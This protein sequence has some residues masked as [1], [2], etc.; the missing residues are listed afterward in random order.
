MLLSKI[1]R[2]IAL[3]GRILKASFTPPAGAAIP[4]AGKAAADALF[5]LAGP[6]QIK[7]VEV[8]QKDPETKL[9]LDGE[10]DQITVLMSGAELLLACGR[11][12]VAPT[13]PEPSE[14]VPASDSRLNNGRKARKLAEI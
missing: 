6:N 2:K 4:A 14:E 1:G 12:A 10:E 7:S 3:N 8:V 9:P 11:P 5:A 13:A